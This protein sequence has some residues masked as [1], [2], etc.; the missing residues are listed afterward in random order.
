MVLGGGDCRGIVENS[1]PP[2]MLRICWEWNQGEQGARFF[3]QKQ[4][5]NFS[6]STNIGGFL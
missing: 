4:F 1:L 3:W 5:N 2:L 6:T